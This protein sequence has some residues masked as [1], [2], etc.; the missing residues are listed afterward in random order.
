MRNSFYQ[1]TWFK[2]I[3]IIGIPA[4][5]SV[6]GGVIGIVANNVLKASLVVFIIFALIALIA[7]MIYY[8]KQDDLLDEKIRNLEKDNVDMKIIVDHLDLQNKAN[9]Q[10]INTISGFTEMWAKNINAFANDIERNGMALQSHWDIVN[11]YD[12]VCKKCRDM[13]EA[14]VGNDDHTK[15]SVGFVEYSK[16]EGGE[17]YINLIAHSNPESTRPRSSK[18]EEKLSESVYYYAELIREKNSDIVVAIN[19]EEILRIFKRVSKD[20]DLSKYCQY[21]A[22]PVF[23]SKGKIMGVFQV[24]TKYDYV[25]IDDKIGLRSFAE[26]NIIPFSN[27]IVLINKINKGLY[28]KPMKGIGE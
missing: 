8:S 7:F 9:M 19:N 11:L 2:N 3:I 12:S 28:A 10:T 18:N 1:K 16:K 25:I 15:I 27:L 21:I 17:E 22:I 4:I 26:S 23:C 6:A 24:V 14:Y 5:I 20:T 13:I